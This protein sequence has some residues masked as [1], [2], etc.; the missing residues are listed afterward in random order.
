MASSG[1]MGGPKRE[2]SYG[3]Q[4][5]GHGDEAASL[6]SGDSRGDGPPMSDLAASI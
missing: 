5:A 4:F 3:S 1:V 2:W 6:R